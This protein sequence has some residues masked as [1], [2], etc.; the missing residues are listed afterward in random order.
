[1]TRRVTNARPLTLFDKIWEQ[2]LVAQEADS[3]AILYIDLHLLHE[4]T[5]PQAFAGLREKGLQ[6]RRPGR[7]LATM[8]HSTPTESLDFPVEDEQAHH[9]LR[10]LQINCMEFGIRLWTCM[11]RTGVLCMS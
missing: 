1:M 11:T 3:P 6:V 9:Q 10:Q 2:H 8:D 7:T 4:V 5:S